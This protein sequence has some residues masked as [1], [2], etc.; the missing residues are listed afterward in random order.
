MHL[1]YLDGSADHSYFTFSAIGVPEKSWREVFDRVKAF[2]H[3]QRVG[4]GLRVSAELHAWKFLSGRGRPADRHLSKQ[5]RASVFNAALQ[6]LAT[7]QPHGLKIL[8]SAMDD[9]NW[10]FERLLTRM[11]V[12][13]QKEGEDEL[14]MLI[15]DEGKEG[16]FTKLYRKMKVHNPIPS[17]FGGW[18]NGKNWMNFPLD[19]IVTDPA[20]VRSHESDFIQLADFCAFALLR[21]DRPTAPMTALGVDTS[22]RLLES[23]CVKAANAGDPYGVIRKN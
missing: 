6:L 21:M 10:A 1:F 5:E 23:V 20:F 2:R 18:A 7:C 12:C 13:M 15:C 19:R 9:E 14:A 4:R 16:H 17:K 3:K 11:N 22:F 8:N